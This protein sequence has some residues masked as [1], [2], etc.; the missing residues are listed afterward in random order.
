[1]DFIS[2]SR[3]PDFEDIRPESPLAKNT[4]SKDRPSGSA[5]APND[6]AN[7]FKYSRQIQDLIIAGKFKISAQHIYND[8]INLTPENLKYRVFMI[9]GKDAVMLDHIYQLLQPE[10]DEVVLFIEDQTND[11]FSGRKL[12]F[13]IGKDVQAK[14]HED[15]HEADYVGKAMIEQGVSTLPAAE[16]VVQLIYA[17]FQKATSFDGL[18]YIFEKK[19]RPVLEEV[20]DKLYDVPISLLRN[21][22]RALQSLQYTKNAWDPDTTWPKKPFKPEFFPLVEISPDH[23][24]KIGKHLLVPNLFD[25]VN[26]SFD[27]L[28]KTLDQSYRDLILKIEKLGLGFIDL[29]V[30][31]HSPLYDFINKIKE[32]ISSVLVYMID[33]AVGGLIFFNALFCGLINS[34]LEIFIGIFQLVELIL[35]VAKFSNKA[36]LSFSDWTEYLDNFLQAL[37]NVEILT[38]LKK[39]KAF[40]KDIASRLGDAFWA[41]VKNISR[42]DIGYCIGYIIGFI[43]EQIL[44]AIFTGGAGNIASIT[45]KTGKGLKVIL[46]AIFEIIQTAVKKVGGDLLKAS[47]GIVDIVAGLIRFI[48]KGTDNI[49]KFIDEIWDAFVRWIDELVAGKKKHEMGSLA[50]RRS[51]DGKGIHLGR[52]KTTEAL[53]GQTTHY[54][55]VATCLRM[56][57]KKKGITKYGEKKLAEMLGSVDGRGV[58]ILKIPEILEELNIDNF[59]ITKHKHIEYSDFAEI[60]QKD[61]IAIVSMDVP[62]GG[63]RHAL[64]VDKIEDG[65]VFLRDPYPI[66]KG[67]S[68]TLKEE[69]FEKQFTGKTVIFK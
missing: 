16:K 22:A 60:L 38:V 13:R 59:V 52:Y 28:N 39:F 30:P 26:K 37:A 19:V 35:Q 53:F 1:M 34:L 15:I 65:H 57:L 50:N 17:E 21:I 67:S 25:Q 43:I 8:E 27:H 56:V 7:P 69:D 20:T 18:Q 45:S 42:A 41:L 51:M 47:K 5:T 48:G 66:N 6:N 46:E 32:T 54:T 64:I 31:K 40:V 23:E 61:E 24:P 44:E 12:S 14:F 68:Y 49:I 3:F 36:A 2:R 62:D 11:V 9:Y 58:S 10:D 29:E 33:Y 4:G 55:C 63:N